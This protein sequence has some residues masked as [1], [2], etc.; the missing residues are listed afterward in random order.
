MQS[1]KTYV[2]HNL[3]SNAGIICSLYMYNV[4]MYILGFTQFEGDCFMNTMYKHVGGNRACIAYGAMLG[5]FELN[6]F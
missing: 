5:G 1:T 3:S 4:F 6:Q 2:R